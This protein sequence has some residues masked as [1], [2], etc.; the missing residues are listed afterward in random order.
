MGRTDSTPVAPRSTD[1]VA[2]FEWQGAARRFVVMSNC[3]HRHESD[4]VQEPVR[5]VCVGAN[6]GAHASPL[7]RKYSSLACDG[8]PSAVNVVAFSEG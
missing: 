5:V 1:C 2:A 8:L 7:V 4:A 3:Y 6:A